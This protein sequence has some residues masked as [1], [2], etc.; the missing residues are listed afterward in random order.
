M[1]NMQNMKVAT[2]LRL[3]VGVSAVG[4]M[5]FAALTYLTIGK[6]KLG[7]S[8]GQEV[9]L[10]SDLAGDILPPALDMERVRFAVRMMMSEDT[11]KLPTEIALYQE[12]K[13]QYKDSVAAW[14]KRLPDGKIKDLIVSRGYD[15][16]EKYFQLIEQ[17]MIPALQKGDRKAA[18]A[19]ADRAVTLVADKL[20]T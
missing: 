20:S 1:L 19:V 8:L 5:I 14:S 15:A 7:G 11:E 13:Q 9:T 6:V 4:L 17:E 12:R 2:K 18:K 3:M 16:A 10:Y